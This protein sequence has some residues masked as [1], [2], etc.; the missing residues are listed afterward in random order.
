MALYHVKLAFFSGFHPTY[1]SCGSF[2]TRPMQNGWELGS[3]FGKIGPKG[4]ESFDCF[5]WKWK[6][7]RTTLDS[8]I[9][10][11]LS[12]QTIL[13]HAVQCTAPAP[14]PTR[15]GPCAASQTRAALTRTTPSP[16]T[17][18]V[19]RD[20]GFPVRL[21]WSERGTGGHM[22]HDLRR[23]WRE[24]KVDNWVVMKCVWNRVSNMLSEEAF[25]FSFSHESKRLAQ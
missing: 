19:D 13:N 24:R 12:T 4:C 15:G 21:A 5:G 2:G 3:E 1:R 25:H 11:I 20:E 17:R 16:C 8:T 10:G 18:R 7:K 9:F 6:G 23:Q 14:S 22:R